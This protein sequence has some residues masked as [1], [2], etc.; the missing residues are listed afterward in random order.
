MP[1]VIDQHTINIRFLW[2][3]VERQKLI[4]KQPTA[5]DEEMAKI[6]EDLKEVRHREN[7]LRDW[8]RILN[9]DQGW[10]E[11]VTVDGRKVPKMPAFK[12]E[13]EMEHRIAN[14]GTAKGHDEQYIKSAREARARKDAQ[15]DVIFM[16]GIGPIAAEEYESNAEGT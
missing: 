10:G 1:A 4:E 13:E 15:E 11:L 6:E 9:Q 14:W 2:L 7:E 12:T 8:T 5:T 3:G 16:D